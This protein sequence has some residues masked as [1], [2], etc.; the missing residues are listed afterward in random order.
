MDGLLG[1][2]GEG[3][4]PTSDVD[5]SA[6]GGSG[7]DNKRGG[8]GCG[9]WRGAI[10]TTLIEPKVLELKRKSNPIRDSDYINQHQ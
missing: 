6:W 4:V 7:S 9:G 10:E 1:G 5:G 2:G 8:G 3:D